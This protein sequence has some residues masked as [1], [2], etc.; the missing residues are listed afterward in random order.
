MVAS[1]Q[2]KFGA[3]DI[4]VCN[5]AVRP[6]QAFLDISLDDWESDAED[7]SEFVLL[8][9]SGRSSADGGAEVGAHDFIYREWM[10]TRAKL[11]AHTT[12]SAKQECHAA[13]ESIRPGISAPHGITANVVAPGW[14]DTV[15]DWFAVSDASNEKEIRRIPVR[16]IGT[17]T[18]I[19]AACLYLASPSAGFINGSSHSCKTAGDTC[20]NAA[21]RSE[22]YRSM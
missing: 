20:F 5:A 17:V 9:C 10:D 1:A 6:H 11:I 16:R 2:Q 19:A 4:V 8:H 18:D 3:L 12:W 15:R 22:R 21:T 7:Q 14:I 13:R